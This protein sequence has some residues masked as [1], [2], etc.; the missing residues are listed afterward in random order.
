M[1]VTACIDSSKYNM[2][3]IGVKPVGFVGAWAGHLRQNNIREYFYEK[4]RRFQYYTNIEFT[5][6][7]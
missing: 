6:F 2:D 4:F 7:Y 3:S 5:D 1:S